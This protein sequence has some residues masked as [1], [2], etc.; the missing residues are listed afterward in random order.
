MSILEKIKS[1][2]PG[3]PER[4]AEQYFELG[5]NELKKRRQF[6]CEYYFKIDIN[7]VPTSS[8]YR[9]A[10]GSS[11]LMKGDLNSAILE[12]ENALATGERT[13]LILSN[14]GVA[15]RIVGRLEDAVAIHKEAV[16]NATEDPE[17]LVNASVTFRIQGC[18]EMLTIT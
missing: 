12:F 17:T 2:I 9:A 5:L 6:Y 7:L 10:Y 1:M 8:K 4:R 14:L 13:A 3:P 15:L 11:L 18:S 16:E